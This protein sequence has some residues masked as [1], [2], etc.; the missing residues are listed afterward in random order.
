M[1]LAS[2]AS[3]KPDTASGTSGGGAGTMKHSGGP[4]TSASGTAGALRTS[5]EKSR[6]GLGPG[7][8]GVAAGAAGF[9]SV[10]SLKSVL[11]SWEERLAGVRDEC[12][13]LEGALL[14]VAKEMGE[15]ETAVKSSFEAVPKARGHR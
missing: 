1:S 3:T 5:T 6:S 4:W 15:T 9:T 10:T 7:H 12:D 13:Y 8:D 14:K 11:K 2:V